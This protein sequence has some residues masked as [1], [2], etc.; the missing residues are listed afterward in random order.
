MT[1]DLKALTLRE[2]YEKE[3]GN[4]LT[5]M[6]QALFTYV[7]WVERLAESRPAPVDMKT[8]RAKISGHWAAI[9][10][11]FVGLKARQAA[12]DIVVEEMNAALQSV[13]ENEIAFKVICKYVIE[14]VD[15]SESMVALKQWLHT[16]ISARGGK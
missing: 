8:V 1:N 13:D 7:E 4:T 11:Q 16:R 12:L 3:T 15:V 6:P 5:D 9:D 2:Q 14:T 10:L